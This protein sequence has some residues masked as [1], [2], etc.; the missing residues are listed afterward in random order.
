MEEEA[1]LCRAA[2]FG[3]VR[4][5]S[6]RLQARALGRACRL[7]STRARLS[8]EQAGAQYPLSL[9]LAA[10]EGD[11]ETVCALLPHSDVNAITEGTSPLC[12]AAAAGHADVV[13]A[14]LAA[15]ANPSGGLCAAAWNGHESCV[16]LLRP[17]EPHE[18]K[19]ALLAASYRGH[20]SLLPLFDKVE[21]Q[22]ALHLASLGGHLEMVRALLQRR[23]DPYAQWGPDGKTALVCASW[24]GHVECVRQ[25]LKAGRL[26]SE[27]GLVLESARL[28]RQ[29]P[30][31]VS[32]LFLAAQRGFADVAALLCAA[33]SDLE[34]GPRGATPLG[35][36]ACS[37]AVTTVH[38]L[39]KQKASCNAAADNGLTPLSLAVRRNFLETIRHTAKVEMRCAL[40]FLGFFLVLIFFV[41]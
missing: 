11:H 5:G 21:P 4:P 2:Q 1:R 22:H 6:P 35:A 37:G 39:L 26:G 24:A 8:L 14:F 23:C 17:L 15:D 12:V 41:F 7:Q 25:L 10:E 32:A 27:T 16:E 34:Q 33:G 20:A 28:C 19:Q 40:S 36:A 9:C 30:G 38:L 3:A 29:A 31:G 13:A 18:C